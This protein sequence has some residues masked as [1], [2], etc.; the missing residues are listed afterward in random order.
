MAGEDS[1]II[2]ETTS[3]KFQNMYEIVS[4][5]WQNRTSE[6]ELG[7]VTSI[8]YYTYNNC[9][10]YNCVDDNKKLVATTNGCLPSSPPEILWTS[11]NFSTYN[12]VSLPV[13]STAVTRKALFIENTLYIFV[14]DGTTTK[15]FVLD[16]EELF[17]NNNANIQEFVT[18][19]YIVNDAIVNG[20]KIYFVTDN[21]Y[22]YYFYNNST[23]N[24][25]INY[26]VNSLYSLSA[27]DGKVVSVGANN[28]IIVTEGCKV[29]RV[30]KLYDENGIEL[31]DN[32]K[33]VATID[34]KI[35]V[36]T[37][38]GLIFC[39]NNCR[40]TFY[41]NKNVNTGSSIDKI[42][43][44]NK[45]VGYFIS[46]NNIFR[47]RDGGCSW[48]PQFK[49]NIP[50]SQSKVNYILVDSDPNK[51]FVSTTSSACAGNIIIGSEYE[52]E[53]C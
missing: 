3:V 6:N 16:A 33:S 28:T 20:D 35:I 19:P 25:Q 44:S 39:S 41:Q 31:N 52:S 18:L 42:V 43:F 51:V 36:G 45:F 40:L 22:T 13:S 27:I 1:G 17:N 12:S 38:T 37:E 32:I 7:L 14:V 29:A 49:C 47:T 48:R 2:T 8:E 24:V 5:N 53:S 26:S 15:I 50:V 46:G 9:N 4:L 23:Q 21:G 10:D 30:A 34:D 11:N